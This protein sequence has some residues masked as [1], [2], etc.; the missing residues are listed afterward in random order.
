[1][2]PRI[3]KVGDEWF[4]HSI[5]TTGI[6]YSPASAYRAWR[7]LHEISNRKYGQYLI[8]KNARGVAVDRVSG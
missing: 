7:G 6:G 2:K 8:T 4:C 1:M 3:K 5:G